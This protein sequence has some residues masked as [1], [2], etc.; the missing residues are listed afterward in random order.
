[1][2]DR[3][4][5]HVVSTRDPVGGGVHCSLGGLASDF[6]VTSTLASQAPPAVGRAIAGGLANFLGVETPFPKDF[7]SY[8]SVG[9]GSVNNAHFLT[10][11]N[12]A[13]YTAF[14]GCVDSTI[15]RTF[16]ARAPVM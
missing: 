14:R 6:I 8:V 15:S 10:A 16:R 2:L 1:M 7:V 13:D 5:G 12:L 11:V 9:D 4:R 3:A